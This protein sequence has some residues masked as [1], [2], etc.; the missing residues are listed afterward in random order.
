[1]ILPFSRPLHA[2]VRDDKGSMAIE[3]AFIA[4]ILLILALG[5]FEASTMIARQ[6]ELQSAAA[7]AA[8]VVRAV[9]PEDQAGRDTVRGI[10]ATSI[11]GNNT[12]EVSEGKSV[13]GDEDQ[14]SVEVTPLKRC[15]TAS[16]YVSDATSCGTETAYRFIRVDLSDTYSPIWTEWGVANGFTYN[17]SRTV[18]VG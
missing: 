16:D 14:I 9:A 3:T 7:E 5:G 15:G 6:T 1:M 13:C 17:V 11:C 8:A 4:P 2:V 12:P 18:Q 10:V